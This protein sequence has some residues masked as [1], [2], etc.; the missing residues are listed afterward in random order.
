MSE[1]QRRYWDANVFLGWLKEEKDKVEACR[2]VLV[3]AQSGEVTIVTS[4]ITLTEVVYVRNRPDESRLPVDQERKLVAFFEN[5]FIELWNAER[6]ICEYAREI[7]WEYDVKPKDCIHAAT[8]LMSEVANLDTY[9]P[10]LLDLDGCLEGPD[11]STLSISPPEMLGRTR[12]FHFPEDRSQAEA[13]GDKY[14]RAESG[15]PQRGS[16]G[17][18]SEET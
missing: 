4:A 16:G 3:S 6:K 13:E 5:E 1:K 11:G 14:P 12:K 17:T 10:D 18:E 9:D 2:D 8:A 7:V 15:T